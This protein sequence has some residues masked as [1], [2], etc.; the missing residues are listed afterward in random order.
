MYNGLIVVSYALGD[1]NAGD[2]GF[3]AV[4][5]SHKSN[6]P[7]PD[8]IKQLERLGPW[9]VQASQ[10]A[11]SAILFTESLTHGTWPWNSDRERRSLLYKYSP[12]HMAWS[13]TYPTAADAPETADDPVLRRIMEPP[14]IG[15][16]ARVVED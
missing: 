5:G 7:C 1:V 13:S 15:R 9:V 3:A 11:G 12:G 16:R 14:Y 8:N 6:L 10:P 2:G 4:P